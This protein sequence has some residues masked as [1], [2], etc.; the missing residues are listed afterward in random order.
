MIV[1]HFG[2]QGEEFLNTLMPRAIFVHFSQL[3]DQLFNIGIHLITLL[4]ILFQ[5]ISKRT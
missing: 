2:I 4:N 1:W 3:V 5:G